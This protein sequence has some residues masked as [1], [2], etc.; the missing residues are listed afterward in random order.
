MRMLRT[1]SNVYICVGTRGAGERWR[2]CRSKAGQD[3]QSD[4][5]ASKSAANK[6]N[7][8]PESE[9]NTPALIDLIAQHPI[10]A[11]NSPF[12]PAEPNTGA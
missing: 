4:I 11:S 10:V 3:P 5:P 8:I 9:N 1:S 2:C 12:H 7:V 6:T